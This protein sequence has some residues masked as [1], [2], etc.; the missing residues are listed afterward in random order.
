MKF[1]LSLICSI[2]QYLEEDDK[3]P[4]TLSP[5]KL[6]QENQAVSPS[7]VTFR[8]PFHPSLVTSP[9]VGSSG[10]GWMEGVL[11]CFKPV[12]ALV[13]NKP[14]ELEKGKTSYQPTFLPP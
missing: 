8:V 14:T 4:R 2:L 11:G 1:Q 5:A 12:F 13:K 6:E 3:G 7:Q 9:G 10:G